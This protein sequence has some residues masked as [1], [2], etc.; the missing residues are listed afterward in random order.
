MKK[1]KSKHKRPFMIISN[2]SD[3]I[4]VVPTNNGTELIMA[5]TCTHYIC[6]FDI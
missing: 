5:A 6:P 4:Q 1:F 3:P 2:G